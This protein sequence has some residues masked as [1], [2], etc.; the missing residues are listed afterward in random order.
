MNNN[1]NY[2]KWFQAATENGFDALEILTNDNKNKMITLEDGKIHE[3]I[4]SDLRTVTIKGLYK[5]IKSSIY[6]EKIDENKIDETLKLIKNQISV[7]NRKE[8]DL[9]FAGSPVYPKVKNSNFNFETINIQKKYDLMFQLEKELSQSIFLKKIDSISYSENYFQKRIVNS[10]G[11]NLEEKASFL[12]ISTSCVFQKNQ[13]IEEILENFTVKD[14]NEMDIPKYAKKIISLGEKKLTSQSLESR[15]YPT[16]FSNKIFAKFLNK[17][18]SIFDGMRAYYN[19][20][21]LKDKK[22][23]KIA[24]SKVTL[25][26]DPLC[27]K[28]FFQYGFDDE[29]VACY[30]K[31]IIKEGIFQDFI[32][33]LKS[34]FLFNTKPSGNSFEN[35][36]SMTNFYLKESDKTFEE[37]IKPIEKGVYIDSLIGLHAGI[38]DISGDFSLQAAGFKIEQGKITSPVKMLV[39]SGNFFDILLNLKDIANDL[40]IRTSGFGSPTVYIGDLTIAGEN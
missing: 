22:G 24:S 4:K 10:K 30:T 6:L 37:M 23:L 5:N 40:V 1:I 32:H 34:S 14:F 12:T 25:I 3:H 21:K 15:T 31:N 13:E 2:K 8:K 36:I 38:D 29:G 33:D 28:A 18:S 20:S 27:N 7:L 39:I 9:V 17:F 16:V 35:S 19:L 26:D 11:V